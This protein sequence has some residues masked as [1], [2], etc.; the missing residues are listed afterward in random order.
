[1]DEAAIRQ[2][3]L[4]TFEGVSV[5]DLSGDMFFFYDPECKFPFVTLVTSDAHDKA[6][7]LGRSGVFRLNIGVRPESYQKRF[8]A[9][10]AFPRDGGIVHTGHDFTALDQIMPH[11]VYAAMSWVCVLNP[12]ARTLTTVKALL[13]EAYALDVAKH[14]KRPTQ[15]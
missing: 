15:G 8:G 10:P 2:Y 11:P 6:S 14:S 1:M 4:G 12:D 3:I 5:T 13:A 7:D 9:Q